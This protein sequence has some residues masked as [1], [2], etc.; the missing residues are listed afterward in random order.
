MGHVSFL[1]GHSPQAKPEN[2]IDQAFTNLLGMGVAASGYAVGKVHGVTGLHWLPKFGKIGQ[3]SMISTILLTFDIS[4]GHLKN[5]KVAKYPFFPGEMPVVCGES[6]VATLRVEPD[7]QCKNLVGG[8][9]K[10][11]FDYPRKLPD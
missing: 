5:W 6:S 2:T 7:K 8:R 1:G 10:F 9:P 11:F 4:L 3:S